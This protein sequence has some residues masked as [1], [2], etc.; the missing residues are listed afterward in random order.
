MSTA[1]AVRVRLPWGLLSLLVIA[2]CISFFDRGNLAVAAPVLAPEL[3]F[4]P[5]TVG[6]LLSAFFWTYAAGQIVSGW[7]VDRV[8]VRWVYAAAFLLWS[9]ATLSTAAMTSFAGLL[10]MRMLLG[11]GESVT[12]P[13][14]SRVLASVF[15]ERRRGLANS[16]VDLGARL[17]PAAGT[18]FGALLVARLGWRGLFLI[19]GSMGLLWLVPWLIWAPRE[20]AAPGAVSP[21]A[22]LGWAQLIRR[23]AVWG[24]CGGLCGANY[25][26]YFLL[27][28]LPSYLVRERHF[29]LTS[30]ALWGALPYMSMAVFSVGG[31]ILAD[32]WISRGA[33]PVKV[34]KRFLVTGLLATAVLLPTVLLP[35]VEWA[36]AGLFLSCMAF[37]IY[38]SN[39]FSLTQTLAGPEAAGRWTGLQ[40]ACGNVAGI[41]SPIVAGWIVAETGHFAAAFLAA[42]LAC[43]AGAASFGCLVK[44]PASAS[45]LVTLED[46]RR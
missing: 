29:T 44:E 41:V 38:A 37:G 30:V 45:S 4:S 25:A 18:M 39:L 19:A 23:K 5:W 32:R 9:V 13:A 20:L 16:L 36:V 35:R 14:T 12:Y 27:S 21:A 6:V 8:E 22:K 43:V 24:T 40:N 17:G 42:G 1:S 15:P 7:L 11:A 3:G 26:W 33:P 46:T 31:G 28:W 34:R 10:S 2:M